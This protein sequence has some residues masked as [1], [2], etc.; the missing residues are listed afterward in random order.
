MQTDYMTVVTK[1]YTTDGRECWLAMHPELEGCMASGWS[2]WEARENLED[3]RELYIDG[4]RRRGV[5]VPG[6]GRVGPTAGSFGSSGGV[7]GRSL[8]TVG[9]T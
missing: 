4:L 9:V 3:A 5:G 1:T 2:E 7:I 6:H 8:P